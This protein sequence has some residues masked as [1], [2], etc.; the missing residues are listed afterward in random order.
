MRTLN[1]LSVIVLA[2]LTIVFCFSDASSMMNPDGMPPSFVG[3]AQRKILVK[4]EPGALNRI[5]RNL[6]PIGRT[7]IPAVD[8]LARDFGVS[9]IKRKFPGA[10]KR[11]LRG[12]AVDLSGWYKIQ[13][14][15][16]VDIEKVV[17]AFKTINNVIDVQPVGIHA[18]QLIPNDTH[19]GNQ[20]HL[21]QSTDQDIDALE[22]WGFETGHS[23]ITVAILDT[24][25][26]WFHNDLGGSD[27]PYLDPPCG[28]T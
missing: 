26:Q 2:L 5:N 22:A 3:Y 6:T 28:R 1:G 8:I 24:G 18:V 25:V 13:F 14:Q 23:N 7:G 10:K 11:F 27:V 19:F 15:A 16:N 21:N 17:A 4:F 12:K 9:A 20:W